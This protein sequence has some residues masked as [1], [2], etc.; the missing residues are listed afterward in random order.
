MSHILDGLSTDNNLYIDKNSN[1]DHI[2][3]N[4][5]FSDSNYQSDASEINLIP[6]SNDLTADW[7]LKKGSL[8][9][10]R[11]VKI[12]PQFLTKEKIQFS[13]IKLIGTHYHN[14][15]GALV[16]SYSAILKRLS[17]EQAVEI[18]FSHAPQN[19]PEQFWVEN[20][21]MSPQEI[22]SFGVLKNSIL[23][24]ILTAKPLEYRD[25]LR[26]QFTDVNILYELPVY[27]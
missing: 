25:T 1:I 6:F 21:I 17:N 19:N 7:Q 23:S 11:N 12:H 18:I 26:K 4:R 2:K 27:S 9:N 24:G 15:L 10:M 3:K 14:G 20:I 16:A 8:E 22:N 13:H 5:Y